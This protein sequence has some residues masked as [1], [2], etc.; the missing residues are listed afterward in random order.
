MLAGQIGSI[1]S[2]EDVLS[3]MRAIDGAL[4]RQ[5]WREMVQFPVV[6][7]MLYF[8]AIRAWEQDPAKTPHGWRQVQRL[9]AHE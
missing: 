3:V 9:H 1:N 7:A 8:E 6:F 5:R 4:P 2:I